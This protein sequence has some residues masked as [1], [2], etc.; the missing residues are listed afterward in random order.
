MLRQSIWASKNLRL[1][2]HVIPDPG[3]RGNA[4][5][6][7]P[8]RAGTPLNARRPLHAGTP[9]HVACVRGYMEVVKCLIEA[10][11]QVNDIIKIHV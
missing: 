11:A 4:T 2:S 8:L 7:R 5:D 10:G 1:L 6:K 9:L 3:V